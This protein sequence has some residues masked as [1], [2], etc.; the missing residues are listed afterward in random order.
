MVRTATGNDPE[1]ATEAR[2][3]REAYRETV[4]STPDFEVI[5]EESI[6]EALENEF[7]PSVANTLLLEKRVTQPLKRNLLVATNEAI[8]RREQVRN[9]LDVERES[10]ER[11][12]NEIIDI[13]QTLKGLP[14]CSAR[15]LPFEK[16]VETWETCETL[17]ASCERLVEERQSVIADLQET[18]GPSATV[19]ALN[20]YLYGGL[21]TTYPVLKSIARVRQSVERYRHGYVPGEQYDDNSENPSEDGKMIDAGH[22]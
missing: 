18:I 8:E 9:A 10:I 4:M 7:P 13:E 5:Y 16:F 2:E 20:K 21:E 22:P 11:T 3:I 15:A 19:H 17:T 12:R 6:G 14:T 1:S